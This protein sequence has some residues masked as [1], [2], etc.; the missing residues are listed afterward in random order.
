VE[1]VGTN[2]IVMYGTSHSNGMSAAYADTM[3]AEFFTSNRRTVDDEVER[4]E[5]V[6]L[7]ADIRHEEAMSRGAVFSARNAEDDWIKA[8][9]A[10]TEYLAAHPELYRD[11]G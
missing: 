2:L 3:Q 4:L 11:S 6:T 8:S 1:A 9:D 7:E 5:A 10:L